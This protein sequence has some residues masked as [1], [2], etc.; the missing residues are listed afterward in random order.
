MVPLPLSLGGGGWETRKG[1][2]GD[3]QP[4]YIE[5]RGLEL[6]GR[7][8]IFARKYPGAS[9]PRGLIDLSW[10]AILDLLGMF[11][12][13]QWQLQSTASHIVI[14]R[15]VQ[16]STLLHLI[17]GSLV[18]RP[19]HSPQTIVSL[20]QWPPLTTFIHSPAGIHIAPCF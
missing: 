10:T 4:L 8:L 3:T 14:Q 13:I 1:T 7:S 18:R 16:R 5:L 6:H 9:S 11:L 2:E 19:L 20:S 15:Q 12:T 17:K